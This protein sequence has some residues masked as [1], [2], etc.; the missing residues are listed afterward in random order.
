MEQGASYIY[1]MLP[2]QAFCM[3]YAPVFTTQSLYPGA[4]LDH[5]R[6]QLFCT[7]C[8][9]FLLVN[10]LPVRRVPTLFTTPLCSKPCVSNPYMPLVIFPAVP[11]SRVVFLQ[12][13]TKT[14]MDSAEKNETKDSIKVET[15]PPPSLNHTET[16][17]SSLP[18]DSHPSPVQDDHE[19]IDIT[20]I[21]A[22]D[23]PTTTT[24]TAQA[25]AMVES[26][27]ID[28]NATRVETGKPATS[29][30][31]IEDNP[32]TSFS[33][34]PMNSTTNFEEIQN[35]LKK[36][37]D[38]IEQRNMVSGF[39]TLSNATSAVVDHCEQLGNNAL[40]LFARSLS[41]LFSPSPSFV[42]LNL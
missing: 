38:H 24:T 11:A 39:R 8:N 6:R 18:T 25:E 12:T 27:R 34:A 5:A 7:G 30:T 22:E 29:D 28:T 4:R 14:T 33:S 19:L 1:R 31:F 17:L 16:N 23:M 40:P 36:T 26:D 20:T 42:R 15:Q 37:L 10:F 21:K 35:Q 41:F 2:D 32:Q 9:P 13:F 3:L